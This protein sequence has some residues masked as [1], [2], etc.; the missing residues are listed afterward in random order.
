M[1]S[2]RVDRDAECAEELL[3][4]RYRRVRVRNRKRAPEHAVMQKLPH[5]EVGAELQGPGQRRR[6]DTASL[7]TSGSTAERESYP[8]PKLS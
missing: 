5:D 6:L 4:T 3:N 1:F 2:R 8:E 7:G